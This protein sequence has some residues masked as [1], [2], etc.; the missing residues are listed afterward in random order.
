MDFLMYYLKEDIAPRVLY[1]SVVDGKLVGEVTITRYDKEGSKNFSHATVQGNGQ[2]FVQFVAPVTAESAKAGISL[3]D[4]T[5]K[6][7]VAGGLISSGNGNRWYFNP[8]NSLVTGHSYTLRVD[9]SVKSVLNGMC[10]GDS[11]EFSFVA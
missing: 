11:V 1:S 9:S 4:E 3:W 7:E 5:A 8:T 2:L 6:Q 10:I